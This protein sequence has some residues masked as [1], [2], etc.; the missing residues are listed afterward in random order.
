MLRQGP[1]T[2]KDFCY[3]WRWSLCCLY[4]H[5]TC[6]RL[7]FL[8]VASCR[9]V[10]LELSG[11]LESRGQRRGTGIQLPLASMEDDQNLPPTNSDDRTL[12]K[13]GGE[14]GYCTQI[15]KMAVP[16]SS[17]SP[18]LYEPQLFMIKCHCSFNKHLFLSSYDSVFWQEVWQA[19]FH[20]YISPARYTIS[21]WR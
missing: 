20:T 9:L 14:A 17:Y 1:S 7:K 19:T 2:A 15:L 16:P 8:G 4:S 21:S 3:C 13:T 12:P 6:W 10:V 5:L 18:H 11:G